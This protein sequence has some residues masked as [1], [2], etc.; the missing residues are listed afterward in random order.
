MINQPKSQP[1][2]QSTHQSTNPSKKEYFDKYAQPVR[3]DHTRMWDGKFAARRRILHVFG[4]QTEE[5][6]MSVT[7]F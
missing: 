1:I 5:V 3:D 7:R 4:R 2:N 6:S